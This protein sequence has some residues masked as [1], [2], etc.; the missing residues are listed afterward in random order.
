MNWEIFTCDRLPWGSQVF[1]VD[2][3]N[4]YSFFLPLK[5][6]FD[7][8]ESKYKYCLPFHT[9][10]FQSATLDISENIRSTALYFNIVKKERHSL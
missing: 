4:T 8:I 5:I 7:F 2:S 6:Y 9:P 3:W 10:S 1:V